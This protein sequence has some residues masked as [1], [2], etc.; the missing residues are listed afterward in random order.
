MLAWL[1]PRYLM[2]HPDIAVELQEA[3]YILKSMH[4]FDTIVTASLTNIGSPGAVKDYTLEYVNGDGAHFGPF[5]PIIVEQP[6]DFDRLTRFR[7]GPPPKELPPI[8]KMV[9]DPSDILYTK[10]LKPIEQGGYVWGRLLFEVCLPEEQSLEF[11]KSKFVLCLHDVRGKKSCDEYLLNPAGL[12][13]EFPYPGL[14][15]LTPS[16]AQD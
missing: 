15:H 1:F 5:R 16:N 14:K 8:P 9:L 12:R 10:T 3:T 7:P 13:G 6:R 4:R 2:P 11:D